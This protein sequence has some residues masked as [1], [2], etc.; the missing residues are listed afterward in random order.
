M[1]GD[2]VPEALGTGTVGSTL[3]ADI[4]L[5]AAGLAPAS[6]SD[7]DELYVGPGVRDGMKS[8][9]GMMEYLRESGWNPSRGRQRS[10]QKGNAAKMEYGH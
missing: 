6:G 8:A 4:L 10:F 1:L 2:F 7:L 9:T 3:R 5:E